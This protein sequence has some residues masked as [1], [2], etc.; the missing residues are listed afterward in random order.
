MQL[1]IVISQSDHHNQRLLRQNSKEADKILLSNRFRS[2][3]ARKSDVKTKA[4]CCTNFGGRLKLTLPAGVGL[5]GVDSSRTI[6]ILTSAR[7][8]L[9]LTTTTR[10]VS[11]SCEPRLLRHDAL[12]ASLPDFGSASSYEEPTRQLHGDY[13]P[14]RLLDQH[15]SHRARIKECVMQPQGK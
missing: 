12:G 10:H 2:L 9:P 4:P 15:P 1:H 7:T 3:T 11:C 13:N 6:L 5:T 14:G 8:S